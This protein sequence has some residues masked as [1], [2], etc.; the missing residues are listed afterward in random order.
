M[1]I[2]LLMKSVNALAIR[3]S[4]GHI[5]QEIEKEH[6]PVLVTR[7]RK[8]VAVLVPI[9]MFRQRF[10]DFMAEDT[11]KNAIDDLH[12]LQSV[13]SGSDSLVDLRKLREGGR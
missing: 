3:K 10:I 5:L 12:S 2:L 9:S 6:T 1:S 8:P 7:D 4:L 13:V 11:L